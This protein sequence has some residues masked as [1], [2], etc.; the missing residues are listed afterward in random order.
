MKTKDLDN[1]I[2]NFYSN[3]GKEEKLG[4][5]PLLKRGPSK[6]LGRSWGE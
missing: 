6:A 3:P 5:D 4:K 2:V 1:S